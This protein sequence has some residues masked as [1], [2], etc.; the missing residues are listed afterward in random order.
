[1]NRRRGSAEILVEGD[2][3]AGGHKDPKGGGVETQTTNKREV[4]KGRG[5]CQSMRRG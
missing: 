3:N 4:E 2:Q 5:I 1:M